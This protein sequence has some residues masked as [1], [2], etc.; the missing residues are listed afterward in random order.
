MAVEGALV[1]Q[2]WVPQEAAA[3]DLGGDVQAEA[4]AVTFATSSE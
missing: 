3:A 2:F 4:E 1:V